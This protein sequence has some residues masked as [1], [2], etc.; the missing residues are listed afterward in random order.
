VTGLPQDRQ[1]GVCNIRRG[2]RTRRRGAGGMLLAIATTLV[3][4]RTPCQAISAEL[5]TPAWKAAAAVKGYYETEID[6]LHLCQEVDGRNVAAYNDAILALVKIANPALNQ[7]EKVMRGEVERAGK[8]AD[9]LAEANQEIREI[10]LLAAK[11]DQ[12][13]PEKLLS[14]CRF[15]PEQAKAHLGIFAPLRD[16][17]PRQMHVVEQW[18]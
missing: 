11:E 10:A 18:R 4:M 12:K 17:F 1:I 3:L 5:D 2:I 8:D 7:I 14:D 16:Q 9:F 15:V 6:T 13:A